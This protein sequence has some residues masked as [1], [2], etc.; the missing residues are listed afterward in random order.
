L[1]QAIERALFIYDRLWHR[2]YALLF[3]PLSVF[4]CAVG[5]FKKAFSKAVKYNIPIISIGNLTVGGSGK[6]P[7]TIALCK[8]FDA[9][10]VV[11]RGYGR[12]SKGMLVVSKFGE[13]IG[14]VVNSGDEAVLIAKKAKNASV[15]VC[16]NR[17]EGIKYAIELGCKV[18]L[19]DDGFGKFEIDKF[20]ILLK[21]TIPL[22]NSLCL[23]SGP[24]RY[25]LFF[26]H[27]ASIIAV[28]GIDFKRKTSVSAS[29]DFVLITAIS[30][31]KRLDAFLPDGVV[32]KH[33]FEDHHFFTKEEIGE[34][35][36]KHAGAKLLCTEKDSVKLEEI[37]I[38]HE[39]IALEA[40]FD[41]SFLLFLKAR[42][43]D[44][45]PS[46][47]LKNQTT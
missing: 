7:F 47:A 42:L 24:Y 39:V 35:L 10:C 41:D 3:L 34:I 1:F 18:V 23:P 21:P 31:P 26:E 14:N 11:L 5:V 30:N 40:V 9:P 20:D 6:T 27:F 29:G 12:K 33:Y 32:S 15:I 37:G 17:N 44:F 2:L 36:S 38:A 46:I 28:D 22:K 4:Y 13:L 19:L 45:F 43:A 25:P 8:E 16:E